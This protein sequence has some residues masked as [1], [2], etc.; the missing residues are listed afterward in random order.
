[1]TPRNPS[2]HRR[3][4]RR[5]RNNY[6]HDR[7][8]LRD[9]LRFLW[10]FQRGDFDRPPFPR[11]GNDPAALR[12][13]R[14]RPTLTWVGHSTFLLQAGGLN[15][16]TDPHF[17]RR[18]SPLN[19]AGPER[20]APLGLALAELPPIDLVLISHNHYDHLDEGTVRWLVRHHPRA[21][22][23]V[24]PGLKR[25]LLR[26]KAKHVAELAWWESHADDRCRVTAV[27]VQHFSGRT[28]TDRDCT[29]WCGFVLETA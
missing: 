2:G 1:M 23:V 4:G 11:A 26:R 21:L 12:E 13:N 25:W 7:K 28:A 16:L 8:G 6:P 18:A 15:V 17:T 14:T 19:W 22:F 3:H 5:F 27:P 29:L 24:P 9:F 10:G 20:V